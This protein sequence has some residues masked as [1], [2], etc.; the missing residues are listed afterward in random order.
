MNPE[1]TSISTCISYDRSLE[2]LLPLI[3]TAGFTHVSLGAKA[4]HS[5]YLSVSKRVSLLGL[6]DESDLSM[7]TI[8]G[9]RLD[10]PDTLSSLTT[11]AEAAAFLNVPVVVVHASSFNFDSSEF[12]K[13]LEVVLKNCEALL[14][15]AE[16]TGVRFALEN[17]LPGPATDLVRSA[18]DRLPSEHFGF[19][20]DSSHDQIGGPKPFDLLDGLADRQTDR[21]TDRLLALHLSDRIR[22]H[23]DHVIPGEGFIAWPVL[24]RKIRRSAY[25]GP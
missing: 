17:V 9:T 16:G 3:A 24:C 15:V 1:Q 14:P 21:Q 2:D 11:A 22:E 5:S 10:L 18:L 25:V 19:C 8:H 13:R 23:V 20:Y 12:D 4:S 6:L 7:D